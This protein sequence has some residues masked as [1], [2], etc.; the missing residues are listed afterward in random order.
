MKKFTILIMPAKMATL[1]L[2][3]IKLLWNNGYDAKIFV[4]DVINKILSR[5][6]NYIVDLVMWPKFGNSSI[7]L[8]EIISA[9][10]YKDLTRKN[11]FWRSGLGS[12][13]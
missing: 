10:I 9:S 1:G 8:R 5:E 6:S 4:Q 2:L 3:K 7:S 11:T 13:S 12:S